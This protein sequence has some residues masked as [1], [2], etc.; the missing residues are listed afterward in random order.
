MVHKIAYNVFR[1]ALLWLVTRYQVGGET[2][3]VRRGDLVT[4]DD[5]FE[6]AVQN[7][8]LAPRVVLAVPPPG[9]QKC[10]TDT[11]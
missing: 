7:L 5:A 1:T 6:H 3:R 2:V 8:G 9:P 11:I 4:F 10:L